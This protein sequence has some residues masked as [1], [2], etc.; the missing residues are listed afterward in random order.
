MDFAGRPP[1]VFLPVAVP[2]VQR[3]GFLHRADGLR[4]LPLAALIDCE[5]PDSSALCR[6]LLPADSPEIETC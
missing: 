1:A 4:M 5:L 3:A 2:G 6:E